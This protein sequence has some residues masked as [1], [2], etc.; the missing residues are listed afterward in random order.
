MIEDEGDVFDLD[1]DKLL[2]HRPVHPRAEEGRGGVAASCSRQ[3]PAAARQ[4]RRAKR[5]RRCGGCSSRSRSGTSAR[6]RP[7]RWPP[8]SARW[9]RSAAPP[10]QRLAA[11]ER[12]GPTIA[13]VGASTGST[14]PEAD[15]HNAIVD[16]WAAAGVTMEDE[17]DESVGRDPRGHDHRGHRLAGRLQPRRR[18]G[19][20]HRAA[21]ARRPRACRRRPTTSWSATTPAPRPRR[22]SSSACPILDEAGFKALLENGLGL[23]RAA[24]SLVV[25][26]IERSARPRR[27][28][29]RR[30]GGSAAPAPGRLTAPLIHGSSEQMSWPWL[31]STRRRTSTRWPAAAL[32]TASVRA[33]LT[34]SA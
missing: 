19:G 26:S 33:R 8:S 15:W 28:A 14:E 11:A 18:Q 3:R 4:P 22:P 7:G 10:R 5:R 29:P 30:T 31:R 12:V 27:P 24:Q 32:R 25:A 13:D 2:T 9:T 17:R 6:P 34:F 21:A 16:K 23:R 20:D 1:R